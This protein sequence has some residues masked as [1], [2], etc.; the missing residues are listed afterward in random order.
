MSALTKDF[1]ALTD[2]TGALNGDLSS[3]NPDSEFLPS[4]LT[5]AFIGVTNE[6]GDESAPPLSGDLGDESDAFNGIFEADSDLVKVIER[7]T[8]DSRN[9]LASVSKDTGLVSGLADASKGFSDVSKSIHDRASEFDD[10][11]SLTGANLNSVIDG[12]DNVAKSKSD[13]SK[14]FSG[15]NV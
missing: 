3:I 4:D 10:G 15:Q 9:L 12:Y 2:S 11:S 7:I 6:S 5:E 13:L 1:S 14:V 8:G